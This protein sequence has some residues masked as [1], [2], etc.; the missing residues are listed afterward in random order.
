[1][2]SVLASGAIYRGFE[3]RSVQTRLCNWCL[4]L[5]MR[6]ALYS[7]YML[8]WIFIVLVYRNNSPWVDMSLHW[9]TLSWFRAN[10]SFLFLL[11]L[12]LASF[13]LSICHFELGHCIFFPRLRLAAS[14]CPLGI[15]MTTWLT[16]MEYLCHKWP[17]IC[18][19]SWREQVNV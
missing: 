7:T 16:F 1:M 19:T 12:Y 6:Y 4:L 14:D 8:S 15:I 17:Q 9:D 13:C 18:S 11:D 3:L 10:Q 2:L 5:L